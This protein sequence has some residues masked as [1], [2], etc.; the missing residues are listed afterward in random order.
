MPLLVLHLVNDLR[1]FYYEAVAAQ[2]GDGAPNHEALNDWSFSGIALGDGIKAIAQHLTDAGDGA[3]S[4][5]RGFLV[6]N[7][8]LAGGGSSF[9]TLA[10]IKNNT[11][12]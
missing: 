1:T 10:E 9:P 2:P 8:Y 11:N 7:G 3:S 12:P 6:P 5:T 4:G